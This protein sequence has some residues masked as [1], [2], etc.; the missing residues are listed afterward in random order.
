MGGESVRVVVGGCVYVR[1]SWASRVYEVV[2]EEDCMC[3]RKWGGS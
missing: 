1:G 2:G 3:A